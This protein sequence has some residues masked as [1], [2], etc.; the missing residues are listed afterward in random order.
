MTDGRPGRRFDAFGQS[1]IGMIRILLIN[2]NA[3]RATTEMMVSIAQAAAPHDV[4]IVGATA[5]RGPPMIVDPAALA[6]S[7]SEVVEIGTGLAKDVSGIIIG[8]FGDPGLAEL[9]GK[10]GIPVAGIAESAMLEASENAGRFGVATSTPALAASID[11]KAAELRLGHLCTGVR[12]TRGDPFKLVADPARLIAALGDAVSACI[13]IDKA[14]S[15]IIGGGPLGA[16]AAALAAR[17]DV[18]VVAPIP[19]AV[20]WLSRMIGF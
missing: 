20:R 3:S 15:V 5:Q 4:E 10:V 6:A 8:A 7:A 1:G 9:R 16:A 13:E 18:P 2:P 12:L 19:A 17:F 14:D 11:A